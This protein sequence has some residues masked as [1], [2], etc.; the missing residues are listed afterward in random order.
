[1]KGQNYPN[2]AIQSH[3]RRGKSI[4][5]Y[6]LVT[7]AGLGTTRKVNAP[8]GLRDGGG[9]EGELGMGFGLFGRFSHP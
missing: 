7:C 4:I 2:L 5:Q 3:V 8:V 1:M 9:A 6:E